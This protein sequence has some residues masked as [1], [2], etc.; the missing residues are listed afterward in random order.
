MRRITERATSQAAALPTMD[1]PPRRRQVHTM[2]SVTAPPIYC[3]PDQTERER[4]PALQTSCCSTDS[5]RPH[6]C[7][8]LPNETGSC[9]I[10]PI[11][12]NEPGMPPLMAFPLGKPGPDLIHMVPF[13]TRIHTAN[14]IS[15]G[16][17]VCDQQSH[18]GTSGCI[19][20]YS[21]IDFPLPYKAVK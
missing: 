6:R 21:F 3:R 4:T 7:C 18:H 1:H 12:H 17:V 19:V 13:A 16:S 5:E 14:G 8:H 15:I 9:R 2:L 10:F 11:L 20:L